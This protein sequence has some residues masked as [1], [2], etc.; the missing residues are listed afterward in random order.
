MLR[1]SSPPVQR[2]PFFT[3]VCMRTVALSAVVGVVTTALTTL[4]TKPEFK[5]EMLCAVAHLLAPLVS[6]EHNT[7]WGSQKFNRGLRKVKSKN[8]FYLLIFDT[9]LV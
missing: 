8:I 5:P 7:K 4:F 6:L 1:A 3:T 9:N 2:V